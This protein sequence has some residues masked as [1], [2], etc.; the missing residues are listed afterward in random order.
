[1]S[2][3]KKETSLALAPGKGFEQPSSEQI[4][5]WKARYGGVYKIVL[6]EHEVETTEDD[7]NNPGEKLMKTLPEVTCYLKK[8][9]RKELA[10]AQSAGAGGKQMLF[11]E[12]LLNVTWL[13]GDE[14]I[15]NDDDYFVSV[16]HHLAEMIEIKESRLEKL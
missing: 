3:T 4:A 1:M 15:K 8:P 2:K 10:Y 12:A 9:G 7:P 13:T 6:P 11:N 5:A 16:G 14:I